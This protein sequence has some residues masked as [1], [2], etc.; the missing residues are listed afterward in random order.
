MLGWK[1]W[2]TR[3]ATNNISFVKAQQHLQNDPFDGL[4]MEKCKNM[5]LGY[6]PCDTERSYQNIGRRDKSAGTKRALD[7][8]NETAR[9]SK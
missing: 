6:H 3:R 2:I 9:N 4:G 1:H 5:W 8:D 7:E